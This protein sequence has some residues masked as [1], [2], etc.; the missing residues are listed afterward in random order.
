MT[1]LQ[2]TIAAFGASVA[3]ASGWLALDRAIA[4]Q[5][6]RQVAEGRG[7][8][9]ET[10]QLGHGEDGERGAGFQTPISGEGTMIASKFGNAQAMIDYMQL[11][12]FNDPTLLDDNQR[13]AVV[14]YILSQH[15]AIKPTDTIDPAKEAAI[16]IK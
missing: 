5:E 1:R 14:A 11:M 8:Y 7:H 3:L 6:S 9:V 15:G 2:L 13:L 16:P 10:C 4:A 12:P